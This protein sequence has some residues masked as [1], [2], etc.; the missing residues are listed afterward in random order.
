MSKKGGLDGN[1]ECDRICHRRMELLYSNS[2]ITVIWDS[3]KCIHAGN[4]DGQLP[5]VFNPHKRPWISLEA[6]PA[7]DIARVID[8]C[9]SGALSYRLPGDKKLKTATI[10]IMNDGPYKVSG[11]CS[12][13]TEGGDKL[14]TS[15][16]FALCRCGKSRKM[17]FCDGSHFAGGTQ[18]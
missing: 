11:E 3:G 14:E 15:S 2:K 12:L 9:P 17:P 10:K 4:C 5:E 18:K 1:S 8:T 13:V 16:P 6:A 7:E